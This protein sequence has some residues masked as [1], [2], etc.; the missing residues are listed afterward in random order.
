MTHMD[1]GEPRRL[2][3]FSARYA[4]Q[5]EIDVRF[6]YMTK[7]IGWRRLER[8]VV[9]EASGHSVVGDWF[10]RCGTVALRVLESLG[11]SYCPQLPEDG[12]GAE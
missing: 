5:D 11:E 10:R 4:D 6:G 9:A 2:P 3:N 1:A 7:E 8:Q 12:E